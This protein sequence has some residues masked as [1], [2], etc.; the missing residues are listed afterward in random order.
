MNFVLHVWS[1]GVQLAA[2]SLKLKTE[3][4]MINQD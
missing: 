4:E 1:L 3:P 2:Q